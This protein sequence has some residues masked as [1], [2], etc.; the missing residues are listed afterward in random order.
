MSQAWLFCCAGFCEKSGSIVGNSTSTAEFSTSTAEK[1]G[2][3]ADF[4]APIARNMPVLFARRG[5]MRNFAAFRA[6][7]VRITAG[8]ALVLLHVSSSER[9][10]MVHTW[11]K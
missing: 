10:F 8:E 2:S 3:T 1:S 5:K 4:C 7:T 6:L 9:D 11:Q